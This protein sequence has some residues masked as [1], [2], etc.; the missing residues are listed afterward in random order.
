MIQLQ[1]YFETSYRYALNAIEFKKAVDGEAPS[2]AVLSFADRYEIVRFD[3]N[4]LQAS[5]SRRIFFSPPA[6]FDLLV[7]YNFILDLKKESGAVIL[8]EADIIEALENSDFISEI[9]ARV[10]LLVSEITFA[11]GNNPLVLP[12]N[13]IRQT[14]NKQ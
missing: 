8:T 2:E 1:D 14:E 9:I 10:S 4:E 5:Y 3:E 7:E 13:F 11:S 12:P 6:L